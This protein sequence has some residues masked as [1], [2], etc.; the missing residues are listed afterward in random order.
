VDDSTQDARIRPPGRRTPPASAP[1]EAW[2]TARLDFRCFEPADRS[3]LAALL[4]DAAAMQ[5]VGDGKPADAAAITR[6]LD[7]A[8]RRCGTEPGG[9]LWALH[10]RA[11]GAFV[12]YCGVDPGEDTDEPELTYA[13]LPTWWGRGLATEAARAVLD[14]ADR[15]LSELAATADPANIASLRI[16]AHLGFVATHTADDRHGLPTVFLRRI[17]HDPGCSVGTA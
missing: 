6:W 7:N 17:R 5:Y 9:G 13:L 3:D 16:L 12:G 10:D 8:I 4:G 11:S 14:L 1:P 2:A 15:T